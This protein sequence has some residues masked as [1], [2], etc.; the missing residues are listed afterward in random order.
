MDEQIY[1]F[2]KFERN[3][4]R[5]FTPSVLDYADLGDFPSIQRFDQLDTSKANPVGKR[6]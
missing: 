4:A 3:A 5:G 2:W 1:R 6:H